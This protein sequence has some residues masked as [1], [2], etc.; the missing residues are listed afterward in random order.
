MISILIPIHNFDV[1]NL[2]NELH[3]QIEKENISY[4]ILLIDDASAE[5]FHRINKT[6]NNLKNVNYTQLDKNIGRS[7][8]RNLLAEKA[9][10]SYLLFAD[11]DT[12]ISHNNFVKNYL[13]K[14]ID[15]T[16]VFGGITYSEKP[17]EK[18]EEYLRWFYGIKREMITPEERVKKGNRLFM[19]GN[20]L[21]SKSIF[22]KIKF[23]ETITRYGHEDTLFAYELKQRKI[24]VIHINNPLV[25]IGLETNTKFIEKTKIAIENLKYINRNY[26]YKGLL[27]DIRLWNSYHRFLF[28][29]IFFAAFYFL[30]GKAIVMNLKSLKP[31]LFLFDLYKLCYLFSLK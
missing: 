25:H 19:S 16:V 30:F 5:E 18:K 22:Q 2:I 24:E 29:K 17:P 31:N 8:I 3:K 13:Q 15:E 20:F 11:C 26:N 7:K 21:I 9:N 14:C 23:N 28:F 12:Q 10:Y 1:R 6:L 4:E 27:N